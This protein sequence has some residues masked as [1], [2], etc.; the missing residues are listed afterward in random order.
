M[1]RK[2]RLPRSERQRRAAWI[3]S[4][5]EGLAHRKELRAQGVTRHHVRVEAVAGRWA[6]LGRHTVGIGAGQPLTGG[7]RLW[8]ALWESGS[9]AILDGVSALQAAGLTGFEARCIDV[10]LPRDSEWHHL[11]GVR[12]HLR[13]DLGAVLDP[14]GLRRAAPEPAAIRA[15]QWAV[16][17]RQAALI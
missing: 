5:H 2:P 6:V 8:W 12:G 4:Q 11:P 15:A 16:S 10:T 9:R 3:A 1:P 17:D 7:A 13:R 14:G